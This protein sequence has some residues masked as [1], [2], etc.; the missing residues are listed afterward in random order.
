MCI[1]HSYI[2]ESELIELNKLGAKLEY[3]EKYCK[4]YVLDDV[5][6]TDNIEVITKCIKTI[7]PTCSYWSFD[8][9]DNI[10]EYASKDIQNEIF[11]I[12]LNIKVINN[13]F[14]KMDLEDLKLL[15]EEQIEN[16]SIDVIKEIVI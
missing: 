5:L 7:Y 9:K 10:K 13:D 3:R 15:K 12:L 14:D 4:I 16:I 2:S 1:Y 11:K 6:R 8:I